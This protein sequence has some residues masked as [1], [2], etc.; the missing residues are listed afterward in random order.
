MIQL[1][2]P[3]KP[4]PPV[5]TLTQFGENPDSYCPFMQHLHVVTCTGGQGEFPHMCVCECVSVCECV[6]VHV[7]EC[8]CVCMCV[9][10]CECVRVCG[11]VYVCIS[12]CVCMYY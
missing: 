5:M 11:T 8:V 10:V 12:E 7:C 4:H 2:A 9:C 6:C 1:Q 3:P